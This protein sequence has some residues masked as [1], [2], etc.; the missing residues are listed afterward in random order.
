MI[1]RPKENKARSR[2]LLA[3][4]EERLLAALEAHE[5]DNKG[6]LLVLGQDVLGRRHRRR[7]GL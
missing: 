1:R 6:A 3:G 2:R 7:C 5:R 4:K